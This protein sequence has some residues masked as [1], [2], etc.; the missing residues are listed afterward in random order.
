MELEDVIRGYGRAAHG[1]DRRLRF[2]FGTVLRIA[3]YRER[4][5]ELLG[6]LHGARVLD[7]GC[8]TGANLSWLVPRVGQTG[9]VVGLD[10]SP[11][12]L[13]QARKRVESNSWSNVELVQGDAVSLDAVQGSFDGILSTYCFG[14]LYDIEQAINRAID[15]LKPNGR[16]V[17]LDFGRV[18]PEGPLGLLYPIY[19][20]M[21]VRYGIDSR[22]DLDEA[23]LRDRWARGKALMRAKLENVAEEHF[24]FDLGLLIHGQ[25]PS[26]ASN[27]PKNP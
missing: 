4:A 13:G 21:L 7:I 26:H 17:I 10:Y 6:P 16:V 24:L 2:W 18:R 27:Q 20:E 25:K 11:A 1:Y 15:R 5:I 8:G 14:L 12:M 22:E 3:K 19:A 23:V 9:Q